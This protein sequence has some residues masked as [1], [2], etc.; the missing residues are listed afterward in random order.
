MDFKTAFLPWELEESIYMKKPEEYEFQGKEN[1]VC[2][3]KKSLYGLPQA[4]VQEIWQIHNYNSFSKCDLDPCV[5]IKMEPH[6]AN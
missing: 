6:K 4:I 2:L 3:L 5:Y 1:Q